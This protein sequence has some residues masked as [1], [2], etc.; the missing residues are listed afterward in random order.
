MQ[1]THGKTT[2]HVQVSPSIPQQA[3]PP[4]IMYAFTSVTHCYS[5]QIVLTVTQ[6]SIPH[7]TSV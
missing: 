6:I 4:A 1:G 5:I 3:L 7:N 2:Q